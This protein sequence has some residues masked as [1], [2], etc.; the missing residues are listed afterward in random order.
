MVVLH[1]HAGLRTSPRVTT[2]STVRP[3]VG[4]CR[5]GKSTSGHKGRSAKDDREAVAN[6][7]KA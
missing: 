3:T 1:L 5:A 2:I 7:A 6:A 4:E